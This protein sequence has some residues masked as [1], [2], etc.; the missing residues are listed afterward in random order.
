MGKRI[1][2]CFSFFFFLNQSKNPIS[3]SRIKQPNRNS[4]GHSELVI[5][6]AGPHIQDRWLLSGIHE[7]TSSEDFITITHILC[8]RV[9]HASFLTEFNLILSYCSLRSSVRVLFCVA[10]FSSGFIQSTNID[11]IH[12]IVT[13]DTQCCPTRVTVLLRETS[14]RLKSRCRL[15]EV[16]VKQWNNGIWRSEKQILERSF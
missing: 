11:W 6:Q 8:L 4:E 12:I 14:S 7:M 5:C 16:H 3:K 13:H 1:R 10:I 9:C 15:L 2:F